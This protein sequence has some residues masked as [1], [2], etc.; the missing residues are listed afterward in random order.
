MEVT[1][2]YT[3]GMLIDLLLTQNTITHFLQ[4]L[5]MEFISLLTPLNEKLQNILLWKI[6]DSFQAKVVDFQAVG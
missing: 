2:Y 1:G 6:D 3:V 5:P 4:C